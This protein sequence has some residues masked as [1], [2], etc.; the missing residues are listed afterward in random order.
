[1]LI[2]HFNTANQK[3]HAIPSLC[4]ARISS[5]PTAQSELVTSFVTSTEVTNTK[6]L[7]TFKALEFGGRIQ[8]G[9]ASAGNS[10]LSFTAIWVRWRVISP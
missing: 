10:P 6:E 3:P 9:A 5:T 4:P 2:T 8:P 1:V 7:T